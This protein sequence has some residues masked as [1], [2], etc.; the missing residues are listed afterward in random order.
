MSRHLAFC[1]LLAI[2]AGTISASACNTASEQLPESS[3][4]VPEEEAKK[5]PLIYENV[6]A[7]QLLCIVPYEPEDGQW[8]DESMWD[9]VNPII[10][11]HGL[12]RVYNT[13]WCTV[14][15][16]R[17]LP[18]DEVMKL[19]NEIAEDDGIVFVRRDYSAYPEVKIDKS[20]SGPEPMP[21]QG[22]DDPKKE[23]LWVEH[24]TLLEAEEAAGFSFRIPEMNLEKVYRT[25][26]QSVLEVIFLRDGHELYR[27]RKG[28]G[29]GN[30][31]G[32]PNRFLTGETGGGGPDWYIPYT[33]LG[34]IQIEGSDV[35]SGYT[36]AARYY[37]NYSYSLTSEEE[38]TDMEVFMFFID[39]K[40]QSEKTNMEIKESLEPNSIFR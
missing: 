8:P 31:S 27:L 18:D 24:N 23:N 15:T 3:L 10:A 39:D 11:E 12:E 21:L 26:K 1:L 30:I 36:I 40:N 17:S 35:G 37:R 22:W 2:L 28:V 9:I 38:L 29:Y 25:Y 34:H 33:H 14:S 20:I 13:S 6:P 16:G 7:E 32:H 4:T 19:M 5:E